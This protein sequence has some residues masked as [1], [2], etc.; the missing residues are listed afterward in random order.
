MKTWLKLVA[1]LVV[2]VMFVGCFGTEDKLE[3]E[4][5][6]SDPSVRR[7]AATQLGEVA[8]PRAL[9]LLEMAR[10]DPDFQVR[11]AVRAAIHEINKRT[12][13]K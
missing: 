5:K 12:F 2:A 1:I 10:D 3:K 9:Q 8:T 6:S 13:M 4:L 11:D 7:E